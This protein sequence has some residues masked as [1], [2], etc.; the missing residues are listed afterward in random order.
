[1]P[2]GAKY[3]VTTDTTVGIKNVESSKTRRRR[4]AST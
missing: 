1:V 2:G 4:I 3:A